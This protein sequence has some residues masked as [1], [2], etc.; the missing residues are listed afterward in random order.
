LVTQRD[1]DDFDWEFPSATRIPYGMAGGQLSSVWYDRRGGLAPT[2]PEQTATVEASVAKVAKVFEKHLALG[3]DPQKIALG[4]FSMGGG[5]A[6]QMAAR[7]RFGAVFSLSSY[8]CDDAKAYDM[9]NHWPPTFMAHGDADDFI[10]P[11]WGA[12]TAD[13]LKL[14]RPDLQFHIFPHVAHQMTSAQWQNLLPF[15]RQ[16]LLS[17]SEDKGEDAATVGGPNDDL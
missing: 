6:L 1:F 9:D 17:S 14:R 10:L 12:K 3:V 4:G 2:F 5:M 7:Y 8:F 13:R 11:E 16:H 15:L